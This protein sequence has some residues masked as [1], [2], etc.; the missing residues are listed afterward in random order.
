M[1]MFVDPNERVPVSLDGNTIYIRAKMSMAVTARVN[2]EFSLV[3]G[4]GEGL[5]GM[6]SYSLALLVNNIVA[7]E[8][9]AF[10]GE[11]GKPIPCTRANIELL[12]PD[13]PLVAAVREEIGNRN[14]RREAPESET[15]PN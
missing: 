8:G 9:P 11:S 3:A 6:G 5:A 4:R 7:W 12:D 14:R 10:T 1:P 15:S 2:D 13:D